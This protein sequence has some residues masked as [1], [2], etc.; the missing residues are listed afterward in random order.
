MA[1]SIKFRSSTLRHPGLGHGSRCDRILP[2]ALKEAPSLSAAAE[3]RL[4]CVEHALATS[5]DEAVK[6]FKRSR[7]T[8][9]RWPRRYDPHNLRTLESRA[10][11]PKQTRTRQWTAD[12]E[13]AVPRLRQA[14]PLWH[15]QA[16]RAAGRRRDGTV[17]IHHWPHPGQPHAAAPAD[18]AARRAGPPPET[19]PALCHPRPEGQTGPNH[20]R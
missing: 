19:G 8:V 2:R 20:A 6:V 17:G 16:G 18:R 13:Q 9:Y 3:F 14:P 12:Q 4:R 15:G 10:C 11:R 7:A 1:K 5:V